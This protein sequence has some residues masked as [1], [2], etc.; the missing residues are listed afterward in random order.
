MTYNVFSGTL[1]P[2]HFTVF[3]CREIWLTDIVKSS[4]RCALET[5]SNIRL[6]SSIYSTESKTEKNKE[7]N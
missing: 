4:I 1:N 5:E 6:A 3:K 7:L 2:T